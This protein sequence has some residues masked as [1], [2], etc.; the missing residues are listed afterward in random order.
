MVKK[1]LIF[2]LY[3]YEGFFY[4]S[5]N[6]VLQKV[7]DVKWLID[8]F[9]F[10]KI[11]DIIDELVFINVNRVRPSYFDNRFFE[12]I[13]KL[14]ESVLVPFSIGG[15]IFSENEI[16]KCFRFGCDKIVFTTA[17]FQK[18]ELLDF[19][20]TNF[21][22]QALVVNIDYKIENNNRFVYTDNGQ[23]KRIDFEK[24]FED[25]L[26]YSPGEIMLN[27]ITKDGTGF[28]Y[29]VDLI[30][31]L[32]GIKIPIIMAGGAGKPEHFFEVFENTNISAAATG[33]LFNFLGNGFLK[34]RQHL[35]NCNL[36]VRNLN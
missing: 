5:R 20:R 33:N 25:V 24:H 9:H 34:V 32:N 2:V 10:K 7:G 11:G 27:C 21:G 17:F 28:G 19:T 23:I 16:E 1:R 22:N 29:D 26:R 6:F 18:K 30:K 35:L 4:L 3:Y 13:E 8:K 31:D 36:N 15:G 12:D 14:L